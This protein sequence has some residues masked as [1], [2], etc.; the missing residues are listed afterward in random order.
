[1]L[2]VP[3][4]ALVAARAMV[5]RSRDAPCSAGVWLPIRA[6][7][8]PGVEASRARDTPA[9][10]TWRLALH[11]QQRQHPE[12][13]IDALLTRAAGGVVELA[14]NLELG[15]TKPECGVVG[16]PNC[17]VKAWPE[18]RLR[19]R[20]GVDAGLWTLEP[21]EQQRNGKKRRRSSQ[22]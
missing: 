1:M 8:A 14:P 15:R 7:A 22:A 19:K 17:W 4:D 21:C 9:L 2:C 16:H 12:R 10:E 6:V 5:M 11:L 20:D 3:R 18:P 13:C